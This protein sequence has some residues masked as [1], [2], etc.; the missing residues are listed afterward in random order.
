MDLVDLVGTEDRFKVEL[1]L[2]DSAG[3]TPIMLAVTAN[4]KHIVSALVTLGAS[5]QEV[6]IYLL[7]C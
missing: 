3:V 7:S 5:L 6:I 1:D 4:S 2:K